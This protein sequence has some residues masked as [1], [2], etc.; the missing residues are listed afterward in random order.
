MSDWARKIQN[1]TKATAE[2]HDLEWTTAELE[3]ITAFAD[4]V[5]AAELAEAMGRTLF[6]IQSIKQAV[7]AGRTHA[8]QAK[9]A[10]SDRP[11]RGWTE[12]D[13]FGD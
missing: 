8:G 11:Y 13:G 12:A 6:A 3:M 1:Q 5:S 4:D 2:R 10:A 9:I 7:R